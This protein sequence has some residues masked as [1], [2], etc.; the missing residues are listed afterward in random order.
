MPILKRRLSSFTTI[1]KKDLNQYAVVDAATL[2]PDLTEQRLVQNV[3]TPQRLLTLGERLDLQVSPLQLLAFRYSHQSR[4]ADNSGAGGLTLPEA[5]SSQR[6]QVDEF[7]LTSTSTLSASLLNE[8]RLGVTLDKNWLTP[9]SNTPAIS[10]AGGFLSGGSGSQYSTD[11]RR[12]IEFG[13]MLSLVHHKHTIRAGVQLLRFGIDQQQRAGFNGQ[14]LFAAGSFGLT[15]EYLGGFD[16]YTAWL[17]QTPGFMPTVQQ[18]TQGLAP[19]SLTQWQAAA[20]I[21]DE[22]QVR[23][24]LSLSMGLRYETQSNPGDIG[25]IAPRFGVAYSF[26]SKS[27][28]VARFRFGIFYR[29]IDTAVALEGLRLSG[30]QTDIQRYGTTSDYSALTIMAQRLPLANLKPGR[31][32]Q[33]QLTLERRI[34]GGTTVQAGYT[35]LQGDR[36]LRSESVLASADQG[37]LPGTSADLFQN[38]L[39][40]VSNGGVRGSVGMV[41]VNSSAIRHVNF[42]GGYLYMNLKTNADSPDQFPQVESNP[43]A[44][45]E[46]A[47]PTWQSR[48]RFFT[49]GFA[50]LPGK[51]EWT[52]LTAIIAGNP[53]NITT[54]MDNNQDGI[55]NDRPSLVAAGTP[56]AIQTP[57]GWLSPFAINGNLPR[58]TGQLPASLTVDTGVSRRFNLHK[59]EQG[60]RSLTVSL[61]ATNLTNHMNASTVNGVLGSPLFLQTIE[62]GPSRRVE[63][64]LRFSF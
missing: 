36:L 44:S 58:N 55:F 29:W 59:S 40:Y 3:A 4:E 64:G 23:P 30:D 60:N 27:E 28:W 35:Q 20:F 17:L 1:E 53:F 13:D 15:G 16:Q 19:L 46:W 51:I 10:V 22:W 32:L 43:A 39:Q 5:A 54:G 2:G 50:Q 49:G 62:A 48:H 63:L 41:T 56:G 7:R 6:S 57:Y 33:P 61:R 11:F 26:G 52:F 37:A 31:S 25:S 12:N 38:R 18:L 47:M 45:A 42:F 21:Q 14:F 34:K 9:N 24:G 8:A